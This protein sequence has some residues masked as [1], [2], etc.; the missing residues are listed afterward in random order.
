MFHAAA[1]SP[2]H[3]CWNPLYGSAAARS[4]RGQGGAGGLW[5]GRVARGGVVNNKVIKCECALVI[6]R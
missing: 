1:R 6:D 5:V 4:A 3:V 2:R